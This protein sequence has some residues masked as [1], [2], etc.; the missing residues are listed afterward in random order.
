MAPLIGITCVLNNCGLIQV[1]IVCS[2]H[3]P[4]ENFSI[5]VGIIGHWGLLE[6]FIMC[7]CLNNICSDIPVMQGCFVLVTS[8]GT[9]DTRNKEIQYQARFT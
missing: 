3:A 1:N 5:T 4:S 6:V 9:F 2:Y 7:K 8:S